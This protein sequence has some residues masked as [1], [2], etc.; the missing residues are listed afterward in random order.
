M[1]DDCIQSKNVM[2]C[3][4]RLDLFIGKDGQKAYKHKRDG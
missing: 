3:S 1:Y 4:D 2:I